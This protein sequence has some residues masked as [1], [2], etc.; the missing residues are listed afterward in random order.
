[1]NDVLVQFRGP[2][3]PGDMGAF[4]GDYVLE[5]LGGVVPHTGDIFQLPGWGAMH[6]INTQ[7][8]Y[9]NGSAIP[10]LVVCEQVQ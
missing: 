6:C 5:A 7:I 1:M 2:G 10:V 3:G 4:Y 8:D 9:H